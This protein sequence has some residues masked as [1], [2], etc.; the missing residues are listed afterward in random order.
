MKL[1]VI[2]GTLSG[3]TMTAGSVLAE[4]LTKKGMEVTVGTADS[5]NKDQVLDADTIVFGSPSW[6]DEGKDGQPLPE[7]RHLIEEFTSADLAQKKV[8]IFGLGD[9]SY[10]HFC[11]AVDVME[12]LLKERGSVP[13]TPSLKI[14]KYYSSPDNEQKVRA[15]AQSLATSLTA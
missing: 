1:F 13:V 11:G 6:E 10:P 8:A 5:V 3:S 15:W 9:T 4:E 7:V 2:Y 14:D 12:G